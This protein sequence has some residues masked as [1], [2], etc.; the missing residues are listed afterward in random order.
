MIGFLTFFVIPAVRGFY[1]SLTDWDLMSDPTYVG[2]DN[3][4]KLFQDDKFIHALQVT[5]SYVLL[6]IPLQMMLALL[7]GVLLDR[8]IHGSHIRSILI[9]PWLMPGVVVALLF[10][11]LLDPGLGIVNAML[12]KIGLPSQGFLGSAQQALPSIAG[13]NIWQYTGYTVLLVLAGLQRIPADVYE[14]AVL[15]GASEWRIFRNITLPLLRPMLVFVLITSVVGSFQIFDTI[16]VTTEGG[17][18]RATQVVYW[19]IYE[20]AFNRL[21][22]GYAASAAFVLF[23]ILAAISLV[24]MRLLRVHESDL[25]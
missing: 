7:I 13:I 6:N 12:T 23:L 20:Y 5:L 15:D 14:A 22:F 10:L 8:F 24:Q 3:Y 19:Y 2:F 11:W 25:S 9:L 16:A 18:A 21:K 1:I 4:R 17:P